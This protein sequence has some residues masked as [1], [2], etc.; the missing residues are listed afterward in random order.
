[1]KHR[2][3]SCALSFVMIMTILSSAAL[4]LDLSALYAQRQERE[5]QS[6]QLSPNDQSSSKP[7][8]AET[9]FTGTLRTTEAGVSFIKHFEGFSPEVVA[10]VGQWGIG[11]GTACDPADYPDGITEQEADGLM[12]NALAGQEAFLTNYIA[13]HGITLT[14]P[15]YDAFASMSYNLGPSWI[16]PNNWIWQMLQNGIGNYSDNDIASAIGVYCH[17]GSRIDPSILRRRIREAQLFL[18]GD[19]SGQDSPS[20]HALIFH[21][22]GGT[23]EAELRLFR[24]GGKYG[25]LPS[26]SRDGYRFT[27][28]YTEDGTH[29]SPESLVERDL[30]VYAGWA[31]PLPQP[32]PEAPAVTQTVSQTSFKDVLTVD[33]FAAYVEDLYASKVIDGYADGTFR[34]RSTVTTGEA[35]KLILLAVGFPEQSGKADDHWAGGYQDMALLYGFLE[36]DDLSEGL[37]APASRAL[38]AKLTAR[39]LDLRRSGSS[40]FADTN[41]D[42]AVAMYQAKI[43]DGTLDPATGQRLFQPEKPI[44]R[45]ELAKIV[46]SLY[47]TVRGV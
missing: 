31:E 20:F 7:K 4:S 32:A 27:G 18:Y 22:A 17:I 44:T 30:H 43:V 46:W 37:N 5:P 34:P 9:V 36:G 2:I 23:T 40:P 26:A 33:W 25:S 13:Q 29:I 6:T 19:Y 24:A 8:P 47:R 16:A 28:W 1:M 15:Q 41:D 21:G 11:Y 39:I 45:A 14:Q 42:Y 35:L 38:I 12:R 3:L 10:D